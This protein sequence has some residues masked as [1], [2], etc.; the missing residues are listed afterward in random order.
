MKEIINRE[1]AL[2]QIMDVD[3][4]LMPEDTDLDNYHR[5]PITE[6]G[7]IGAGMSSLPAAFR[8]VT[9]QMSVNANNLYE[10]TN[11]ITLKAAKEGRGL[12]RGFEMGKNGI[13]EQG[14]FRKAGDLKTTATSTMPINPATMCMAV[15]IVGLD[16]KMDKILEIEQTILDRIVAKDR[17]Q[18]R[19]NIEFLSEMLRD[20]KYNWNNERF[21]NSNHVM[22]LQIKR[23]AGAFIKQYKELIEKSL[24]IKGLIRGDA[25]INKAINKIAKD[26][27]EYQIAV[28][29]YAF[30]SFIEVMLKGNFNS[31]YLRKVSDRIEEYSIQYRE[32]YTKIYNKLLNEADQTVESQILGTL[33]SISKAA[34][35]L[36]AKS[37]ALDLLD[38]DDALKKGSD[39]LNKINTRKIRNELK[40]LE[41]KQAVFIRPFVQNIALVDRAYNEPM[42]VLFDDKYVYLPE[43]G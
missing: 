15:A 28:Y 35:K 26:M 43:V 14:L 3:C 5:I 32:H 9:T 40:K 23:E 6:I 37:P 39:S 11:D 21:L 8:T 31:E 22:V 1:E 17:A 29:V 41:N 42:Q 16:K 24:K 12:L 34:G 38:V 36:A 25:E 33:S 19:N 18:L 27:T 4:Y 10:L 30:A 7:A 13:V 20:Y 2:A